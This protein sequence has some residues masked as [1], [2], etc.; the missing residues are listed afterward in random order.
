[1]LWLG[2]V[3]VWFT[4]TVLVRGARERFAC[5][6]LV[7]AFLTI[8]L[9]HLLNPDAYIVRANTAHAR[10]GRAFDAEY[11]ASLSADAV[12]ALISA[13]PSLSREERCF[14]ARELS[15]RS[16]R[17][18]FNGDW[19][20]WN[21]ARTRAWHA[22]AAHREELSDATC[23]PPLSSVPVLTPTTS[24]PETQTAPSSTTTNTTNTTTNTTD[25]TPDVATMSMVTETN[26]ATANT[27]KGAKAARRSGGR[28]QARHLNRTRGA[29]RAKTR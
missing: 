22:V 5:G 1:M 23:P 14:V 9:L 15:H 13:L 10:A 26:S 16:T 29:Q 3:F 6:A 17:S 24:A 7:A 27:S 4:W 25:T 20:A 2:L 21:L 11:A 18:G 19:R 28:G 12:P 8:G